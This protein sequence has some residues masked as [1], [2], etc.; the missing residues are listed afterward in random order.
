MDISKIKIIDKIRSQSATKIDI[1]ER[2]PGRFQLIIPI[3]HEDGDMVDVYIEKSPKGKKYLRVCDYGMSL[4]RLSYTYEINTDTRQSIFDSILIDNDVINDEGNLY[5]ESSIDMLYENIF[6]FVGC[7]QK[8]C[9]MQYWSKDVVRSVFYDDLQHYI[10]GEL[11]EFK[12]RRNYKPSPSSPL[13]KIDWRLR[14]NERDVF[15]FGIASKEKARNVIIAL[16]ES[17]KRKLPH[18]GIVVCEN[19]KILGTSEKSYLDNNSSRQYFGMVNFQDHVPN[20]IK[21]LT[22]GWSRPVL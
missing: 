7:V 22:N 3:F 6:K 16:L 4:M 12:P 21:Q 20:D 14:C 19:K 13:L 10:M 8:I 2:R 9:S 15:I 1:F 18:T 17:Q 5:L 11:T